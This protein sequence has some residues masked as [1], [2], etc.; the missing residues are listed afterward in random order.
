MIERLGIVGILNFEFLRG[1]L[2]WFE[3]SPC[4]FVNVKHLGSAADHNGYEYSN[5][6]ARSGASGYA[7]GHCLFA[8]ILGTECPHVV[9]IFSA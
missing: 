2:F 7:P 1:V 9:A 8:G 5:R 4:D 3:R 6:A